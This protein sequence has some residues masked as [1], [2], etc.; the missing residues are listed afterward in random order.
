MNLES[1]TLSVQDTAFHKTPLKRSAKISTRTSVLSMRRCTRHRHVQFGILLNDLN[2]DR[3]IFLEPHLSITVIVRVKPIRVQAM[4][5]GFAEL[6]N[7]MMMVL[8]S[9][10][11]GA[12]ADS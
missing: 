2:Y 12:R 11:L 4:I 7:I 1:W 10:F 5:G 6:C 3:H 8:Q 9:F